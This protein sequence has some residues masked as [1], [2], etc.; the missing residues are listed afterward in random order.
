M[1]H[2]LDLGAVHLPPLVPG[3]KWLRPNALVL[4]VEKGNVNEKQYAK[5][6]CAKLQRFGFGSQDVTVMITEASALRQNQLGPISSQ[7]RCNN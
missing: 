2:L 3:A 6:V 7:R 5:T 4:A 1:R